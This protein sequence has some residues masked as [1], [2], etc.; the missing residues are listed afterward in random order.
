MAT[1]FGIKKNAIRQIKLHG[2]IVSVSSKV[3]RTAVIRLLEQS[4]V[5]VAKCLDKQLFHVN[6]LD[7]PSSRRHLLLMVYLQKQKVIEFFY[8]LFSQIVCWVILKA[9]IMSSEVSL[10]ANSSISLVAYGPWTTIYIICL[11]LFGKSICSLLLLS[12]VI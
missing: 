10:N 4:C 2:Y 1:S 8:F 5:L 11:S 3:L 9:L 7:V 12:P 6:S